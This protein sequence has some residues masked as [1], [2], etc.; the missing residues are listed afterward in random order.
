MYIYINKQIQVF[1]C[2]FCIIASDCQNF[3]A[4]RESY[5][6]TI[7]CTEYIILNFR[8]DDFRQDYGKLGMLCATC[9]NAPVLALTATASK[10]RKLIKES[11]GLKKCVELVANLDRKNIFYATS[12][13]EG[14]DADSIENICRPIA[15]NLLTMGIDYPLT[16]IYMPLKW[17]GYVYRL[18]ESIM[19]INQ[20]YPPAS[21][22]VPKN[23]LFAQFHAPQTSAMKEE[24]LCRLSSETSILRVVFATVA[25]G[26][27]VDIHV[28]QIVHIGPPHTIREYFQ[29]TGRAGRDGK[30]S[31]AILY[32]NNRDISENKPGIQEEIKMYCRSKGVCLRKLLLQY[33]DVE[34]PVPVTS[35]HTCCRVCKDTC[36]C[37]ECTLNF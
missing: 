7:L 28:R 29:E 12:F 1:I 21:L 36:I 24:I 2:N 30:S 8:G 15:N 27:D 34:Q 11:L 20:Y 37:I 5:I 23:R 14:H 32:Y 13:R 33:L 9:P 31:K 25:F 18:F 3:S 10:D 35:S 16:I 26:M 19:G 22:P 4:Y 17:C 6:P